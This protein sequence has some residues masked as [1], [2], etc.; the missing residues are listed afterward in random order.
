MTAIPRTD[1][2]LCA[3]CRRRS[4]GYGHTQK[5]YSAQPVLWVCD[6]P[7]CLQTAKDSYAMKQSQFDRLE[8]L[9]AVDASNKLVETLVAN[10]KADAF[11]TWESV[12]FDRM[13]EDIISAYRIALKHRVETG[14][15]PF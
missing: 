12:D 11:A 13:V 5:G 3:V 7:T 2:T 10:G 9:A 14:E 15:A 4:A 6:D 1:D 8:R